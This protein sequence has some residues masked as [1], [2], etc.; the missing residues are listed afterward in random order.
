MILQL[1]L[2]KTITALKHETV[3]MS[4]E[5]HVHVVSVVG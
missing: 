4:A 2:K 3:E 5:E 1:T